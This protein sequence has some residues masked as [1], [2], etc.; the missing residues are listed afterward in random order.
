MKEGRCMKCGKR[1]LYSPI[2]LWGE[3]YFRVRARPECVIAHEADEFAAANARRTAKLHASWQQICSPLYRASQVERL[4]LARETVSRV[5]AWR[6]SSGRWIALSGPPGIG[7]RRL[8]FLL[9]RDLHFSG[10]SLRSIRA[11]QFENAVD[12]RF[13][14]HRKA[15]AKALIEKLQTTEVLL[16]LDLGMERLSGASEAALHD[17]IETRAENERPILWTS[18]FDGDELL[19]KF[20]NSQAR[21]RATITRLVRCSE[22]LVVTE[23]ANERKWCWRE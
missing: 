22:I 5:L 4:P 2:E 8:L 1:F 15:N 17:L 10:V 21:G 16:L 9:A 14:D 23:F 20:K 13:D 11:V 19:A 12:D 7:K 6:P 3:E 18:Q